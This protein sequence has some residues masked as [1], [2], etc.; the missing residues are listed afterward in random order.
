MSPALF[1]PEL[2]IT[3]PPGEP[4]GPYNFGECPSSFK[5][6]KSELISY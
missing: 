5:S 4:P 2:F 6:K 1:K 3:Q